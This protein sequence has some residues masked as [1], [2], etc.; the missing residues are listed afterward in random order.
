MQLVEDNGLVSLY[1]GTNDQII[2]S[3]DERFITLEFF[4][5]DYSFA[6]NPI[7]VDIYEDPNSNND[8]N[9]L[10]LWATTGSGTDG[11]NSIEWQALSFSNQTGKMVG[12]YDT[13]GNFV[14]LGSVDK[15]NDFTFDNT[16]Q[17]R[18]VFGDIYN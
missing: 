8:G 1:R 17:L 6:W 16:D 11:D 5:F 13:G 7:I 3:Y 15:G 2:V 10:F 14:G 9:I 4:T 12:A 18:A